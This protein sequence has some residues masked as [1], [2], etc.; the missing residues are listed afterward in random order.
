M[1]L[2]QQGIDFL[3]DTLESHLGYY[4]DRVQTRYPDGTAL[5]E[6]ITIYKSFLHP[7]KM[8]ENLPNICVLGSRVE[9]E[10]FLS[11]QQTRA[12]EV[13]I[14]ITVQDTDEEALT[15]KMYRY[16]EAVTDCIYNRYQLGD[17]VDFCRVDSVELDTDNFEY[18]DTKY[19]K[20]ALIEATINQTE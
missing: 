9:I 11:P 13:M 2:I 14:V 17:K 1:R 6:S 7:D 19:I 8:V 18:G 12:I 5:D 4:I 15:K 20:Q 10:N 3:V 16:S